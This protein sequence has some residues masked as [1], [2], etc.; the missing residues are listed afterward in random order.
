MKDMSCGRVRV[1]VQVISHALLPR[2]EVCP[3]SQT[4]MA[5]GLT[6]AVARCSHAAVTPAVLVGTAGLGFLRPPM[7]G[8][9]WKVARRVGC[10]RRSIDPEEEVRPT[11]PYDALTVS[12]LHQRR[13][14]TKTD[15][16]TPAWVVELRKCYLW[17]SAPTAPMAPAGNCCSDGSDGS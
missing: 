4:A 17:V 7:P 5:Y 2:A 10:R 1:E 13:F 12:G 11:Q 6:V 3:V 9:L 14:S 16:S 8:G 15:G